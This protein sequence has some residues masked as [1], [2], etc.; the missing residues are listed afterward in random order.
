MVMGYRMLESLGLG[1][2]DGA[3]FFLRGVH[4]SLTLS[5]WRFMGSDK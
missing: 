1:V 2:L 3:I 4:T 5:T